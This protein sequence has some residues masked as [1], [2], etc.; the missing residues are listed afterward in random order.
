[1]CV[2]RVWTSGNDLAYEGTW[3][4]GFNTGDLVV[5]S[6]WYSNQPNGGEGE[7]CIVM[8]NTEDDEVKTQ[9]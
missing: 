3:E 6:A 8:E 4:W 5:Y 2:Q 7:D 9:L 1:M